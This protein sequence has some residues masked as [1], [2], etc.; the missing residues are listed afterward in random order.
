MVPGHD[1]LGQPALVHGGGSFFHGLDRDVQHGHCP[2][3][4]LEAHVVELGCRHGLLGDAFDGDVDLGQVDALGQAFEFGRAFGAL[5]VDGIDAQVLKG[6]GAPEAFFE[7]HCGGGVG[8]AQDED[9]GARLAGID[10]GAQAGHGLVPV[11][12]ADAGR[13]AAAFGQCL[14]LDHD[15]G[16]AGIGVARHRAFD[17]DGVA[18][19]GVAIADHRDGHGGT[20]VAA[21]VEHLGVG[22]EPGVGQAETRRRHR[23]AA[24]EGQRITGPGNDAGRD[25]VVTA[26]QDDQARFVQDLTQAFDVLVH[27][28]FSQVGACLIFF[29]QRCTSPASPSGIR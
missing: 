26:R 14:V 27:F 19:A 23:Q 21:L 11:D 7:T 12:H 8:A 16:E 5:Q 10:G 1:A 3:H 25:G 18:V 9:V 17:V 20:D 15:A 24:H 6:L 2:K 4:D 29:D 22:N 28:A 13:Q